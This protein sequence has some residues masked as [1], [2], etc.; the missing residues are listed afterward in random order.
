MT[1]V[2]AAATLPRMGRKRLWRE[3]MQARFPAGT[4]RRIAGVLNETEDRTDFVREAVE[5]ELERREAAQR[6]GARGKRRRS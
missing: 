5:R 2:L 6:R 1:S 3:D 4:F